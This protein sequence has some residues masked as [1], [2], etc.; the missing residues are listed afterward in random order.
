MGRSEPDGRPPRLRRAVAGDAAVVRDLVRDAYSHYIPLIGRT[1]IPMLTDYAE[2]IRTRDVWVLD[3]QDTIVGVLELDARPDHLWLENVAVLPAHQ[4][5]GLGKV[6]LAH[7]EQV[8][9]ERELP[10]I[11]LLTNERYLANIAMYER[12]GYVETHRQP[13]LGTDLVYF[14]KPLGHDR[15]S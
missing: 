5:H 13:H 10:E 6:L 4:G 14:A 11:R 3:A 2:A 1:P 9:R 15:S 8:A 7:A 12:H